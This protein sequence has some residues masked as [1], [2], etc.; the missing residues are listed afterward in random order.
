MGI[1]NEN[2]VSV[3]RPGVDKIKMEPVLLEFEAGF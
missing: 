3:F 2:R 1:Q